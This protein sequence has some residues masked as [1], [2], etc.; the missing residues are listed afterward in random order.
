V[1]ELLDSFDMDMAWPSWPVNLW[2]T[3]LM[4][5]FYPTIIELLQ[6]RDKIVT[7]WEVRHPGINAYDDR[8]LELT[9]V[10]TISVEDQI[11]AVDAALKK[12]SAR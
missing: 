5:L 11:K 4:R 1:I 10:I 12:K 3:N 6:E 8:D 7:D 2:V 9:S